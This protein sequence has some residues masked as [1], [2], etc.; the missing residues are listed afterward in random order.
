MAK[1][2]CDEI[3]NESVVHLFIGH[4]FGIVLLR[5]LIFRTNFRIDGTKWIMP[6][7]GI[8]FSKTQ[9]SYCASWENFK[10]T[11]SPKQEV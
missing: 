3:S 5:D 9:E 1:L 11:L 6:L 7:E 2:F 4:D 8:L 10:V